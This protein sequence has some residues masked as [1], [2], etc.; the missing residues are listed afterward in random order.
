MTTKYKISLML[1]IA[2]MLQVSLGSCSQ[3]SG[4]VKHGD[5]KVVKDTIA[6]SH[7]DQIDLAGSFNVHLTRGDK[8]QVIIETDQN[9]LELVNVE[10]KG[11]TLYISSTGN[12]IL[13]PTRLNLFITYPALQKLNIGGACKIS[14]DQAIMTE[15]LTIEMS[16]AA[17][18]DLAIETRVLNTSLS[19]AGSIKFEGLAQEHYITLSGASSLRAEKLITEKTEIDLSGAGSAQVFASEVFK[20]NLS[21]VGS[22][23]YHGNPASTQVN[24][25]GLGSIKKAD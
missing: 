3:T 22:I 4:R 7:F 13:R 17:E 21:G 10:V 19:G 1:L 5:G 23:R 20:A 25:S 18:V 8:L 15:A 11:N 6:L 16:G 9:L 2:V 14:A 24:K 12:V